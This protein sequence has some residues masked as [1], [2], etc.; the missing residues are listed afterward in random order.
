ML[1]GLKMNEDDV[2]LKDCATI[3]TILRDKRYFLELTLIKVNVSTISGTTNLVEGC[4]RANIT[5]SN[6]TRFHLNGVLY[7]SKSEEICSV[8][9]ISTEM[10]I[11]LKL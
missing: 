2:C 6:G 8:L 7:S 9:K 10:D 11:I 5:L 1:F 4:G 3:H